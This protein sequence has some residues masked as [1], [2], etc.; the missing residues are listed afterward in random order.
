MAVRVVISGASG[1][2][3]LALARYYLGQGAMVGVFARRADCLQDLF[4]QFPRQVFCYPLDVRDSTA[5][6]AAAQSFIARAGVPDIVIANAGISVGTLTEYAEDIDV[7]QQVMDINMSGVLKTFQ[8]FL[9]P[10]RETGQGL[11]V[12]IASVAGFRGLPGAGAYSAS[13]AALIAYMESLRVELRG[14][15]MRAVTICP[16]YIKTPMT[17]VNPYP[18]PFILSADEAARRIARVIA[19]GKSFAVVPWQMGLVG[20]VLKLLPN[21]LYDF[22]FSRAPRK[23]RKLL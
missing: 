17:A 18:M 9:I 5:V 20:R 10:M 2:L 7:F 8:P 13:K 3:G 4:K 22:V 14:S 1:G 15:G 12:G 21:W 23:P 11:L 19:S 6:Q 16:G